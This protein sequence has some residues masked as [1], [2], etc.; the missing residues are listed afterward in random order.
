MF[1]WPQVFIIV[2]NVNVGKISLTSSLPFDFL[3]YKIVIYVKTIIFV[4]C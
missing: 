2:S 1:D 4:F 3:R